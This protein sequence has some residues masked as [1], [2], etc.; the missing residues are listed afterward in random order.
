MKKRRRGGL[1]V[2]LFLTLVIVSLYAL[3]SGAD[4]VQT[5]AALYAGPVY[6]GSAT[7]ALALEFAV[8]WD[9]AAITDI[10]DVLLEKDVRATFAVSGAYAR[11][12]PDMVRRMAD[13]GHELATMGDI[14]SFDGN[15]VAIKDDLEASLA[16]IQEASGTVPVLYFSGER[17]IPASARAARKLNLTHVLCTLNLRCGSGNAED[18]MRRG[19]NEPIIGSIMLMQPTRAGADALPGLIEGL[20]KKGLG[21]VAVSEVIG[22]G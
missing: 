13:E 7:D 18:I 4:A 22:P 6:R 21:V 16:S 2:N 9:A 14:P 12:R 10:L 20:S 17:S 19:L 11:L 15:A 3:T 5:M 1:I 8:D